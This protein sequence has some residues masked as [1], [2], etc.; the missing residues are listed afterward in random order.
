MGNGMTR[1]LKILK[2]WKCK[3]IQYPVSKSNIQLAIGCWILGI[4][5]FAHCATDVAH[6]IVIY[7]SSPAAIS[8]AVQA[9]RMVKTVAEPLDWMQRVQPTHWRFGKNEKTYEWNGVD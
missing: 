3:K 5:T 2:M 4:C 6:D 1:R 8:A 9:K 7:G